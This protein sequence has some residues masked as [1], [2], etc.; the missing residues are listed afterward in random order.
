MRSTLQSVFPR[1][2]SD[3]GLREFIETEM[4]LSVLEAI[5]P[6]KDA[7]KAYM[8]LC[9]YSVIGVKPDVE[10]VAYLQKAHLKLRAYASKRNWLNV[11]DN[12]RDAA[13][14]GIRQYK[15]CEIQEQDKHMLQVMQN[16]ESIPA[17]GRPEIYRE[18]ILTYQEKMPSPRYAKVGTFSYKIDSETNPISEVTLNQKAS[19]HTLLPDQK[20]PRSSV[21]VSYSELLSA[22]EEIRKEFPDDYC[23]KV[24]LDN[25]IKEV[26][27]SQVK[28]CQ[29]LNINKITNIV[30]MVGSGKSTLIKV[31][32]YVLAHR[33][34]KVVLV[35]DTVTEVMSLFAYFDQ[36]HLSVSPLVGRN[37][38]IKYVEQLIVPG[39]MYLSDSTSRY[40]TAACLIDGME[41]IGAEAPLFGKEPCFKLISNKRKYVCPYF[42]VCPNTLMQRDAIKSNIVITTVAGLAATRI[43][44]N[45]ILFADYVLRQADLVIFDECDRVQKTLDEFF[46]PSTAFIEFIHEIAEECHNDLKKP[47]EQRLV[48]QNDSYYE[49]LLKKA[50]TVLDII[51]NAVGAECGN[52]R[53]MLSDTFSAMTLLE[54]LKDEGISDDILAPLQQL[55]DNPQESNLLDIFELSCNSLYDKA[56]DTALRRWLKQVGASLDEKS[57]SHIKLCIIIA[58][59]DAYIHELDEV[60]ALTTNADDP[61]N[62][63]YDFLQARFTAQQRILPSALIGNLFGMKSSR[64]KGLELYRQYAFGRA[65]M[66]ELPWL[67]MRNDGAPL[68]PHVLLLS[69]SSWAKGCLEYHVNCPVNYLL[70]AEQWKRDLLAKTEIMELGILDRVSGGGQQDR[71]VHLDHVIRES[72]NSIIGELQRDGKILMIVNSY[73]EAAYARQRIQSY[74]AEENEVVKVAAMIRSEDIAQSESES[75]PRGGV[76]KFYLHPARILVAPAAAIERGYNIVDETG[77]SAISSVFFLVRPMP[78]P[79][80]IGQRCSKLNGMVAQY[81][82]DHI[83]VNEFEKAAGLRVYATRQW[84]MMEQSSRKGLKY[85]PGVLKKDVTASIFVLILQIFGRLARI[86][87]PDKPAPRLYF[88]DGA[89]RRTPE[90]TGGYDCLN[91]LLTYL[92]DMMDDSQQGEIARTLYLPFYEAFKKGIPYNEYSNLSDGLYTEDEYQ[93]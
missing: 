76:S 28:V 15:I 80:D 33:D 84:S 11:L 86:T 92:G 38:R 49:E 3:Y 66:T 21:T 1:A 46:S 52:W 55:I 71:E 12:Y 31:L 67:R 2:F 73:K 4:V 72:I 59:F 91:E 56:F 44:V 32:T 58:K 51:Q 74:L 79:D 26:I 24:L 81:Y 65:L 77:H 85:L 45:R 68:G 22:A 27:G 34:Q 89:F 35:V 57:V 61:N 43:G 54:R 17:P 70:E 20:G 93:D 42:N 39:E 47:N 63:L 13:F 78:V 37:E 14:D 41:P 88:A 64:K 18:E 29:C 25:T 83:S 69:G 5:A 23:A 19:V 90:D 62:Q 10:Q 6:D 30:G 36:L 40:L 8:L 48:N 60:Y 9:N 50:T 53:S 75:I 82:A 16:T 7:N 87:D